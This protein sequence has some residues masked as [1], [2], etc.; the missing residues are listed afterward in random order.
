MLVFQVPSNGLC[1]NNITGSNHKTTN[2][3]FF[4]L[5]S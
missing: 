1:A 4:M 5:I 3:S 2:S